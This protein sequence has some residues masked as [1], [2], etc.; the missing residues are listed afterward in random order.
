MSVSTKGSA[1]VNFCWWAPN[2][3]TLAKL[4]IDRVCLAGSTRDQT[5]HKTSSSYSIRSWKSN[6]SHDLTEYSI[7][8]TIRRCYFSFTTAYS[9]MALLMWSICVHLWW[10]S[11]TS[12]AS[13][14]F[15]FYHQR[16]HR[17]TRPMK[18]KT[19]K[20]DCV[21]AELAGCRVLKHRGICALLSLWYSE[22][23]SPKLHFRK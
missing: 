4:P 22:Q 3:N 1:C 19:P 20:V 7:N 21:V 15:T 14:C 2:A 16:L 13:F 6:C 5:L 17:D 23:S 18:A 9:A 11:T 12:S 8:T 10:F